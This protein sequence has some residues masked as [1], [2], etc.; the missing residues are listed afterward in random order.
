MQVE[1]LVSSNMESAAYHRGRLLV[2]FKS[3]AIYSYDDVPIKVF[4]ELITAESHGRYF[5]K[6]IRTK[7][8]YRKEN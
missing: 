1:H 6:N 8:T 5:S 3:G 2:T 4:K 7:Y